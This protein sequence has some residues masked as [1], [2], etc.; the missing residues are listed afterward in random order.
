MSKKDRFPNIIGQDAA[1]RK[2]N[3]FIEGHGASGVIPHLMFVAPK[4]SGKTMLAKQLGRNLM[5]QHDSERIGRPKKFLEINCSTL[6]SVKQF[7]NQIVIPHI[8]DKECNDPS[9]PE[10]NLEIV[11][12]QPNTIEEVKSE[13]SWACIKLIEAGIEQQFTTPPQNEYL[14]QAQR[15]MDGLVL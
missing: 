14:K 7:F 11:T 1:K 15:L 2:L 8:N 9:L 6:K 5:A 4:G 3:F 10:C 12:V 13:Y